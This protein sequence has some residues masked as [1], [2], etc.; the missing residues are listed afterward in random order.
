MTTALFPGTFDPITLGHHDILER[1]CGMFGRVIVAVGARHDKSTIF[2]TDERVELIRGAVG[3]L[4]GVEVLPFDGLIV[5]FAR[6]VG[7]TVLVRGIRNALDFSYE[8]QMAITNRRLA[9]EVD[10]VFLAADPAHAFLSSSL[11]KEILKAGGSVA[12]FVPDNVAA[13]LANK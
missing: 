6:S 11:I 3:D 12:E 9:A 7:A 2:S 1:A 10:T 4:Q 13:A 8:N 5:E